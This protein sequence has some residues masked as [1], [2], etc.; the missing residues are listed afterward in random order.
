VTDHPPYP[1]LMAQLEA[2]KAGE[3][4]HVSIDCM[5]DLACESCQ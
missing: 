3:E 1:G 5:E 2:E 4:Y